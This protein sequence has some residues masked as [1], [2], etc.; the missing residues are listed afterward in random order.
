MRMW[1]VDP[2]IMCNQHLLG[3]HVEIHMF[4][5]TLRKG[6][7]LR[8]YVT[9]NLVEPNHL[10]SRHASLYFEMQQRG[11]NHRSEIDLQEVVSLISSLPHEIQWA[12]VDWQK[13][14]QDLMERCPKCRERRHSIIPWIQ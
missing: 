3:E 1:M 12:T 10:F 4:I 14:L 7:S 2:A 8:G 6:K 5:G 11:M 9:N 13:S